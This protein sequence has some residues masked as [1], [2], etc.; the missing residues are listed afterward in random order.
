MT[1]EP[2]EN[3]GGLGKIWGDSPPPGP[4]LKPPLN[5]ST[6]TYIRLVVLRLW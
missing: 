5:Y 6:Y 2:I 3:L 1:I 4:R